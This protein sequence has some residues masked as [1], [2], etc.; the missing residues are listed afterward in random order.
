MEF[1]DVLVPLCVLSLAYVFLFVTGCPR[2]SEERDRRV[3]GQ[4]V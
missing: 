2:E 1:V 3:K 4:R